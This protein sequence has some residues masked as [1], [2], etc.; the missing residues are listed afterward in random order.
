MDDQAVEVP[1]EFAAG[2][3]SPRRG[4]LLHAATPLTG[5]L[6]APAPQATFEEQGGAPPA[7]LKA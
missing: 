3:H 7:A 1:W 4:Q 2:Y 5:E 6:P